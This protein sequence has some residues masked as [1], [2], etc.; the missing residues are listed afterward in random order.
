M[1]IFLK[2]CFKQK[3]FSFPRNSCD[4]FCSIT[5]PIGN[6][7]FVLI[8]WKTVITSP[9]FLF[10]SLINFVAKNK[11]PAQVIWTVASKNY[12]L[13]KYRFELKWGYYKFV[14]I[15]ETLCTIISMQIH[16]CCTNHLRRPSI[17]ISS[18]SPV[19]E[20]KKKRLQ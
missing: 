20:T 16:T 13:Y 10:P 12:I 8:W 18:S 11:Q 2:H 5:S 19:Q 17:N 9:N 7:E 14:T 4:I 15:F 1:P 6:S 3:K